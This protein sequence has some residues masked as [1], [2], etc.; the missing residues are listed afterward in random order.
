[1][2]K[3]IANAMLCLLLL[4]SVATARCESLCAMSSM[5]ASSS[6]SSMTMQQDD[7]MVMDSGMEHC[8]GME[9]MQN[10]L[11]NADAGCGQM[12]CRHQALPASSDIRVVAD[13]TVSLAAVLLPIVERVLLPLQR[14]DESAWP[15][16]RV[17]LTP[18]EQGSM[19]RV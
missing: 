18:L 17:S 10:N 13:D 3:T 1:M 8:H 7:A 6:S 4:L 2:R 14:A 15:P 11:P 5:P 19:L 16:H 9:G 12:N